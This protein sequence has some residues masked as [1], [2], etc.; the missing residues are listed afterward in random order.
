MREMSYL[1]QKVFICFAAEDRYTIVEPLVYHLRNY[2]ID[3]WYDRYELLMGD[4]RVRKNLVDGAGACSYAIIVISKNTAFSVCAMEEIFILRK[5]YMQNSITV[6]PILYEITPDELSTDLDWVKEIIFKEVT[7][8]SGTREICNHIACRITEDQL[9]NARYKSLSDITN[10]PVS[11]LPP[12][13]HMII[14]S[15]QGVDHSNLICRITFLYSLFLIFKADKQSNLFIT[16]LVE[17]IFKRLYSETKLN[18]DVDYREIWLLENA[19]CILINH[20]TE[21]L[22]EFNM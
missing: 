15:Y 4:N 6:F 9:V 10:I 8:N 18:I 11:V 13:T 21:S 1:S 2:G 5:R 3:L 17:K 22:T 12:A 16:N 7:H 20:Y 19:A 14:E